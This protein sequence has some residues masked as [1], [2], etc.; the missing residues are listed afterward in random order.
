MFD[1]L[2]IITSFFAGLVHT[3]RGVTC[4]NSSLMDLS[5]A[6]EC[7]GAVNYAKSF[8]SKARYYGEFTRR[9]Y[10]KGCIVF[11]NSHIELYFN[12]HS[13]GGRSYSTSSIC[14]TSNT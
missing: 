2:G 5:T 13:T 10:P 1:G 14:R 8:N 4:S 12:A 11:D 6:E 3:D 9:D 7:S